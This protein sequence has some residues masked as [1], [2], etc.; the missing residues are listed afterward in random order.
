MSY[1]VSI[2]AS[3]I[4]IFRITDENYDIY[5]QLE[6]LEGMTKSITDNLLI[7]EWFELKFDLMFT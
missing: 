5:Q 3:S 4:F 6:G 1:N 7:Q 2:T